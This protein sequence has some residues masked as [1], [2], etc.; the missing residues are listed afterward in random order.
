MKNLV[1]LPLPTAKT[2][3]ELAALIKQLMEWQRELDNRQKELEAR[4][5]ALES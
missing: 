1:P 5:E 4:L 3:A 2:P